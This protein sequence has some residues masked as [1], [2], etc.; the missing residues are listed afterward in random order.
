MVCA[1][2][3]GSAAEKAAFLP[4]ADKNPDDEADQWRDQDECDPENPRYSGGGGA[5]NIHDCINI[6]YQNKQAKR[7]DN[8]NS[9]KK[10]PSSAMG[11]GR[12]SKDVESVSFRNCQASVWIFPRASSSSMN[13][14]CD[15]VGTLPRPI[16]TE[17]CAALPC[18]WATSTAWMMV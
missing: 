6:K 5:R 16:S 14:G 15:A 10:S 4:W 12:L 18:R 7:S 2:S 13:D 9:Q 8:M 3:A 11:Q 1:Y 17:I